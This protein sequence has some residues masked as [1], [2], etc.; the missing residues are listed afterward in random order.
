MYILVCL[1]TYITGVLTAKPQVLP[2]Y[3]DVDVELAEGLMTTPADQWSSA[4][5]QR[6]INDQQ[7][8]A[9]MDMYTRSIS[10][11]DIAAITGYDG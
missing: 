5:D 2:V 4:A 7:W 9:L 11:A 6:S 3:V 1:L 8:S 10:P